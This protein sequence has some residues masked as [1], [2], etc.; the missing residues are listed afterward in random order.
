MKVIPA[1]DCI[2]QHKPLVFDCQIRNIKDTMRKH[3]LRQKIMK[4]HEDSTKIDFSS[5]VN[6]YR[7]SRQEDAFVESHG[8]FLKGALVRATDKTCGWAVQLCETIK[9]FE[10]ERVH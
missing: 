5:F 9:G 10:G 3:V 7:C 6:K 4:L 1:E 2:T 8:N